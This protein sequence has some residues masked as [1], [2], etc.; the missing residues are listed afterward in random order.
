MTFAQVMRDRE[1]RGMIGLVDYAHRAD[2]DT[3]LRKLDDSEFKASARR[4][5]ASRLGEG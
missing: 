3:A 2:M 5:G 4:G 1:G